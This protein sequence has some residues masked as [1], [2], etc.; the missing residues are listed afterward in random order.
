MPNVTGLGHVGLFVQDPAVM[1][2]FYHNFL[3]MQVTDRGDGDWIVFLSARPHEEHHE[4][5]LM[6]APE[7]KSEVQQ[8]SFT[9]GSLAELRQFWQQIKARGYPVDRVVNHGIAFGCYFRD[10]EGNRVEIY[11]PTGKDYPQPHGDPIDL[12]QSEA[13]LL[14]RLAAMPPKSRAASPA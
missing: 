10:P 4:L 2:D 5:A 7:R 9:V 12:D 8:I 1:I 13:E 6:R 11:W 14:S 3:G